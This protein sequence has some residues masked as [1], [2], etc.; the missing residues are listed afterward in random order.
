MRGF[1]FGWVVAASVGCAT[2][3][4]E[5]VYKWVDKDGTV[6]Y[7]E[8]APG[9]RNVQTIETPDAP[10]PSDSAATPSERSEQQKKMIEQMSEDRIK[11]RED[12]D[13]AAKAEQE[14]KRLCNEWK[15]RA[16]TLRDGGRIYRVNPDGERYFMSDA[17]RQ[18]ELANAEGQVKRYCK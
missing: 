6:H 13:K 12:K 11:K 8:Y 2:A 7:G 14:A 18:K 9:N 3:V 17:E 4:A 15:T 5:E 1:V 16:A 10:P